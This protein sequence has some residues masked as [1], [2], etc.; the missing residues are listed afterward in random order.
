MKFAHIAGQ[1]SATLQTAAKPSPGQGEALLQISRCGICGSDLHAWE[2]KWDESYRPGHEFCGEVQEIGPGVSGL[3]P[4]MRVTGESFGHC[5]DCARCRQGRYNLCENI[6]WNP[7]R[8][9]GALAQYACY[10]AEA[11]HPVPA[12]LSGTQAA[13]TEPLAVALHALDRAGLRAGQ[14]VAVIGS[15]TIGLLCAAVA[16][17]RD[18]H[19]VFSVAKYKHQAELARDMGATDVILTGEA[20]PR[21]AIPEALET[22]G[23]DIGVD[24]VAAGT[25]LSVALALIRPG[26]TMVEVGGITRPLMAALQPMVSGEL[27]V[28]GASC[29]AATGEQPDMARAVELIEQGIINPRQLITH[30]YPLDQV[31][32]AFET[33]ADKS[34]G[35][36]KV[37]VEM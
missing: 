24:S 5:G 11:L 8:P 19:R 34:T 33:A 23:V 9:G 7:S 12:S 4:G 25:S 13:L 26:G 3:E 20:D 27:N 2:G 22:T 18:A 17:A 32:S 14:T 1:Q 6:C 35:S 30:T 36:V 37:M 29:Y 28:V 21:E 15:G 31:Q 16:S 10:R